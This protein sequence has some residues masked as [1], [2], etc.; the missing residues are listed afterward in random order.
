[1]KKTIFAAV[2][3]LGILAQTTSA[4]TL[5]TAIPL[6]NSDDRVHIYPNPS[7]GTF[8]ISNVKAGDRRVNWW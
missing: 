5:A 4:Q 1:M 2:M 8:Y 3:L 6:N 7:G